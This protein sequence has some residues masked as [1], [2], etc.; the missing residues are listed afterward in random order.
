MLVVVLVL[1]CVENTF[2][3]KEDVPSGADTSVAEESP[4]DSPT[5]SEPPPSCEDHPAPQDYDAELQTE[6]F[7]QAPPGTFDPVVEWHWTSSTAYPSDTEVIMTP[8]VVDLT[9]DGIP[10]V[11][12]ITYGAAYRG[13]ASTLRALDGADGSETWAARATTASINGT[14]GIGAGDVDGDGDVEVFVC[15]VEK[16]LVAFDHEGSELWLAPNICTSGEDTPSLHDLEGDG[17]AEIIVGRTWLDP[18]GNVLASGSHGRGAVTSYGAMSF[19]ADVDGDGDLEVIAG[20][21]VYQQ[22]GSSLWESGLEDGH[23]AV[24]DLE[25]DGTVD[26]LVTTPKGLVRYEAATGS[27]VWGPI[28]HAGGGYGGAPTLADFDGDGQVE[29]GV[30]GKSSYIVYEGDGSEL[31]SRPIDEGSVAITG[32]SVFDFEGDGAAEV[33]QADHQTL[34]VFDGATGQVELEWT[35]H[36]SGTVS[37]YPVV[38]DVDGDDHAEIIL[39]HNTLSGGGRVGV[40]VLG[41]ANES[42][43]DS[44][45]V[46]NQAAFHISHVQDDGSIPSSYAPSWQDHNSFRA[47]RFEGLP[48]TGLPNVLIGQV[49]WCEETCAQGIATAWV[50][51]E[52][53][54]LAEA[55]FEVHLAGG[56]DVTQTLTLA[57]GAMTWL[58]PLQVHG[59]VVGFVDVPGAVRECHEDDNETLLDYPCE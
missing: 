31:W 43:V 26:L 34:W 9:G 57:A 54:G 23:P 53:R 48:T 13:K 55:T 2:S 16:H 18:Q 38:A 35:E 42:W 14:S 33:V 47:G 25:G 8:A 1:A 5:D 29:I 22:D 37:E 15:T 10:E 41:D 44:G 56:V 20:N 59:D 4:A 19:A 45:R 32:A 11:L 51:V 17:S 27:K 28:A 30:A 12:V 50:A 40:T 24:A 7:E 36:G 49:R 3:E 6:C 21:A 39:G 58:G 52:N 46:W